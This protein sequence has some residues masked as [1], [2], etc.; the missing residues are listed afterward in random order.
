MTYKPLPSQLT[1]KTSPI[2]GL[3]L[4]ATEDLIAGYE[5]GVT[6][7]PAML[8][9]IGRDFTASRVKFLETVESYAQFVT[10]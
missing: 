6:H 8:S 10:L 3:G 2:H 5:L 9:D 4:Y 7:V 1:I